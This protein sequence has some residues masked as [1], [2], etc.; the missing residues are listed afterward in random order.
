MNYF[1][2]PQ[3]ILKPPHKKISFV[4]ATGGA[5]FC[6]SRALSLRMLP[7]AGVGKFQSIGDRIGLPDDVTMGYIVEYLLNVPLTVIEKFHSH[8]EPMGFLH[9]ETFKEQITF[10]HGHIKNDSNVLHIAGFDLTTDPTRFY[11]LHCHLF[12]HSTVP[13]GQYVTPCSTLHATTNQR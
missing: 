5:G 3:K 10:S 6:I 8:L 13:S 2:N 9:T 11:S 12:P 7:I 1:S 4:F